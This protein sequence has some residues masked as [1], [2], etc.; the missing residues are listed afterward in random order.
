MIDFSYCEVKAAI[1]ALFAESEV[2]S[3]SP[4]VKSYNQ[5]FEN[6]GKTFY[7]GAFNNP[8]I[9]MALTFRGMPVI[10][11][12][13]DMLFD[14]VTGVSYDT[15]SGYQIRLKNP[16][17]SLDTRLVSLYVA[18][19]Y[20]NGWPLGLS[21]NGVDLVTGDNWFPYQLIAKGLQLTS[22]TPEVTLT[23]DAGGTGA[24]QTLDITETD[25]IY[26]EGLNEY[27]VEIFPVG[28]S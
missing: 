1:T 23:M 4:V 8:S 27:Y 2:L 11:N 22:T 14:G 28:V 5:P 13:V 24:V 9:E 15:F 25:I 17:E 7:Y 3:I 20:L 12:G 16:L 10:N 6:D 18:G 19:D 21:F 26:D